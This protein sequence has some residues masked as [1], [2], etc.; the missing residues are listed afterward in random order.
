MW[1]LREILTIE[2]E[3]I[4]DIAAVF[5]NFLRDFYGKPY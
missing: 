1:L 2:N 5:Q 3:A 4:S